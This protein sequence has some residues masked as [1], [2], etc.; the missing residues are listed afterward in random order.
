MSKVLIC[1]PVRQDE[2]T[3]VKYL[4]SLKNL[5]TIGLQVDLF[6]ILHN[7]EN[8]AK[9][10]DQDEYELYQSNNEY[11]KTDTHVW[12]NDNL[13]DV[14]IMKNA[15]IR[16]ALIDKYDYFFLV[17]SD[18]ILHENTLQHLIKQDKHIISEIF[19][20]RWKPEREEE[21]NAWLYDFYSFDDLDKIKDWRVKGLY[22]VGGTGASILIKSE[23]LESFV[24]YN[25]I[26][27]IS[28]SLWEDRAFC[29]RASVAG[30]KI[31]LDT[32]Y[33][34]EHLYRR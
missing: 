7:S 5:N 33:P 15:L 3:F 8:L 24:N 2:E 12:S 6:F 28:F 29:I 10:L 19:W 4:K 18:L 27:N 11:V 26:K 1:A 31:Y 21:P 14:I 34:A 32:H 30:F 23:V 20:T 13:K 9:Y 17:D 25:P 16:K 22:E